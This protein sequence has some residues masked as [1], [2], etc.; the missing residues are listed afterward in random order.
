M[1]PAVPTEEQCELQPGGRIFH[2]CPTSTP[3]IR[4]ASPARR[5]G[6][7]QTCGSSDKSKRSPSG[8]R[9]IRL[10]KYRSFK[11]NDAVGVKRH[12]NWVRVLN[13]TQDTTDLQ[14]NNPLTLRVVTPHYE[15]HL[16]ILYIIIKIC[17]VND[18]PELLKSSRRFSFSK[19][20]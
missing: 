1:T 19:I 5:S 15:K 13:Y 18:N 17:F 4:M 9:S 6:S 10:G 20:S 3:D 14:Q 2:G 8:K 11:F 7:F 12:L 16:S